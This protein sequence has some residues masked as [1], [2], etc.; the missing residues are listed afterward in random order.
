MF[1]LAGLV[2]SH[3][4]S[5]LRR[6]DIHRW[7]AM[8]VLGRALYGAAGRPV[9]AAE[10]VELYSC[11]PSAVQVQQRELAVDAARVPTVT[12][13]MAFAG[14]PFNNYV[15]QS[16]AEV[17]RRLRVAGAGTGV[18][19]TVSG[20]LTKPGIGLWGSAPGPGPAL[21]ADLATEVRAATDVVEVV[22]DPGGPHRRGHGGHL[23]R[24]L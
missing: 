14:G 10:V 21:I 9:D 22:E 17:A 16:T 6:R 24:D 15:L 5:L 11:F 7:P 8:A 1:P 18:V 2:S 23:H 4:V 12:G 3:A 19:T 13:G 20:L